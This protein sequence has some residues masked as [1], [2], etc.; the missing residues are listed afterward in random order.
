MPDFFTPL[1]QRARSC[2]VACFMKVI[3]LLLFI[4]AVAIAGFFQ[5][6]M[7][8]HQYAGFVIA[9]GY[10]AVLALVTHRNC[11]LKPGR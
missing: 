1:T 11:S 5:F 9:I 7:S 3:F 2:P 8:K 10:V 6:S 4:I